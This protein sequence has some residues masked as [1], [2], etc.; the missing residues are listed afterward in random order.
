MSDSDTIFREVED[1]LR[2]EQMARLWD[3][4][5][6]YALIAAVGVVA[7][8]GAFTGYKWYLTKQAQDN[9]SAFH[10]IGEQV[11]ETKYGDAAGALETFLKEAPSGYRV[12]GMLEFAALRVKEG[13]KADAVALYDKV[14]ADGGADGILK[15]FAR[16]QAAALR[17]DEADTAEMTRRLDKL[18]ADA[19]PWRHSAREL[20]ALSAYRSGNAAESETLLT[21]ILS[22]PFAPAEMRRRAESLLALLVK[23]PVG[24]GARSSGGNAPAPTQK[25]AA[26][27]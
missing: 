25:D 1:D 6:I 26:T 15:E 20:L 18:D 13:R 19:S 22:D 5:G 8:V 14:A 23:S 10:R 9:G 21:R 17:V 16:L 7:L 27:Q 24:A 4:Y 2:R 12:L 11:R 3:R